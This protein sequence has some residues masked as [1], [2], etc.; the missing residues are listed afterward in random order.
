MPSALIATSPGSNVGAA[1]SLTSEPSIDIII[2]H[3]GE[4]QHLWFSVQSCTMALEHC[5]AQ[6]KF[7]IV[8]NG[9]GSEPLPAVAREVL[10]DFANA[11]RL[12]LLIVPEPLSPPSARNLG[13]GRGSGDLLFFF[14]NHVLPAPN[15]FSR[16]IEQMTEKNID[17]LHS[18]WRYGAGD[19][20][21]HYRLGQSFWVPPESHTPIDRNEPYRCAASGHGGF[22]LRRS[23]WKRLHGYW[24]GFVEWGGEEVYL[25]LKM[26]LTGH[27]VWIDP[28]LVHAHLPG[29]RSYPRSESPNFVLNTLMTANI[30]GGPELARETF[31]ALRRIP[32]NVCFDMSAILRVALERSAAHAQELQATFVRS[33]SQQLEW[34]AAN[35]VPY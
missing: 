1:Q 20:R 21:Y 5:P 7:I 22:I 29:A 4:W 30:L 15:Y 13:A 12:D 35:K 18:S 3:R 27:E 16:A 24:G 34:F 10:D 19:L 32:T 14:D 25:D 2:A 8:D 28:K 11:G 6:F 9:R 31:K 33:Y 17:L 26:W 23:V